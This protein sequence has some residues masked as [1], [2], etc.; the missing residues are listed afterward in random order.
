MA[1][2]PEQKITALTEADQTRLR[3]QRGI[4]ERYL[5]NEDS[6]QKY[7]SAAGKLGTIRAILQGD[8]FK[9]EQTYELQCLGIVLGDAL[10]QEMG[11][12]WIMVEDEY[13]RDPAIQ[14]PKTTIILYPMTMISKRIE[15]GEN[16]DVFEL[17]NSVAVQVEELDRQGK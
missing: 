15:R 16:V 17:F 6:K 11:M 1:N 13:G 14:M 2:Q 5:G 7:K 12:E 8:V 9:R 4:V 10:V 3:D